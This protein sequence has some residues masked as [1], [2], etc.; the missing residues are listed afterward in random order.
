MKF[1]EV[2]KSIQWRSIMRLSFFS[3]V[4]HVL[5]KGNQIHYGSGEGRL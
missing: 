2:Y 4:L 5:K 3:L 1:I